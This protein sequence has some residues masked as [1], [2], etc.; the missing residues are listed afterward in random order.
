[1]LDNYVTEQPVAIRIIKNA[2]D[3]NKL[4]HAYLLETNGYINKELFAISLAKY[5][6]CPNKYTN[7]DKCVNCTQCQNIDK[8]IFDDLKIIKPADDSLWIKKDQLLDLQ[9]DLATMSV[10]SGKKVYIITD[11]TKLNTSSANSML[12]FLEEPTPNIIAILLAD[13]VHQLLDTIVSRCQILTLN[14]NLDNK[15]IDEYLSVDVEDID[16]IINT[17][18]NFLKQFEQK[19]EQTII[20]AKKLFHNNIVSKNDL[21]AAFEMMMLYYK[22]ALNTKI[23][24][25]AELFMDIDQKVLENSIQE[26]NRRINVI[27]ELKKGIYINAN[28]NL[29]IDELIM[30]LG[31]MYENR[32]Y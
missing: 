31:G 24:G 1:M 21:I 17:I 32:R 5:L 13:N 19:K 3:K 30:E 22:D 14:P 12:K 4:S 29:L 9:K 27:L 10:Q 15:K 6:L 11:A 26:L 20:Y 8:N 23:N 25:Q 7:N 28:T 18:T 16:L 2:V